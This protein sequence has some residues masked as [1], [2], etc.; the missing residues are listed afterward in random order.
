M[1]DLTKVGDA[2]PQAYGRDCR[3]GWLGYRRRAI[4]EKLFYGF[5]IYRFSCRAACV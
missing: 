1:A 3:L 4:H 2:K 5:A